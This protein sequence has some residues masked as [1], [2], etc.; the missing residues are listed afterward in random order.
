MRQAKLSAQTKITGNRS[1][2]GEEVN[3][4]KRKY[5]GNKGY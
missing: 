1:E 4:E 5:R 3:Q 2:R